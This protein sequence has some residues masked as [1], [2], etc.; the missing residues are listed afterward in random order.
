MLVGELL[1]L[2]VVGLLVY[3]GYR[4]VI[5][6]STKDVASI[7]A[8]LATIKN[9][10]EDHA[11]IKEEEVVAHDEAIKELSVLKIEATAAMSDAKTKAET[12]AK[13]FGL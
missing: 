7:M 12:L 5:A 10:L 11:A 6:Q 1:G 13:S 9:K 4:L 2:G 3:G 8:P